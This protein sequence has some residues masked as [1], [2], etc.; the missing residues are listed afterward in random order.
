MDGF[1]IDAVPHLFE[2]NYTSEPKS[3]IKRVSKDDII[4]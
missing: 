3:N 2:T 4:I 1:R